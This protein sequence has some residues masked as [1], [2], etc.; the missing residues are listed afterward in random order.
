MWVPDPFGSFTAERIGKHEITRSETWSRTEPQPLGCRIFDSYAALP[1][2]YRGSWAMAQAARRLIATP[3]FCHA[4]TRAGP[5][6]N[7]P[8]THCISHSFQTS[9]YWVCYRGFYSLRGAWPEHC[10]LRPFTRNRRAHTGPGMVA[11][12]RYS[13]SKRICRLC[14]M[15]ALPPKYQCVTSGNSYV[16]GRQPPGGGLCS[17]TA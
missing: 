3:A 13:S 14:C 4:S 2:R 15:R 1:K 5:L 8:S 10:R 7:D 6:T 17:A 16:Q 12:Q 9:A 11:H